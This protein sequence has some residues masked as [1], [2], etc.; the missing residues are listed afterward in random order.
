MHC[1]E[2]DGGLGASVHIRH[3]VEAS[4]A[5]VIHVEKGQL[6]RPLLFGVSLAL[7]VFRVLV[8][9]HCGRIVKLFLDHRIVLKN[10][11]EILFGDAW[12]SHFVHD[13]LASHSHRTL[14]PQELEEQDVSTD[15]KHEE[16]DAKGVGEAKPRIGIHTPVHPLLEVLQLVPS[17]RASVHQFAPDLIQ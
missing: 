5:L 8:Q 11:F 17:H 16:L 10:F 9:D 7:V 12:V 6:S 14:H 4:A 13:S 2:F 3:F 1:G 15:R